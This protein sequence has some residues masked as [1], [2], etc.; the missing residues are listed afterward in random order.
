MP[1]NAME[2]PGNDTSGDGEK[3]LYRLSRGRRQSA[4]TDTAIVDAEFEFLNRQSSIDVNSIV[5]SGRGAVS[6]VSSAFGFLNSEGSDSDENEVKDTKEDKIAASDR[7]STSDKSR[8]SSVA[9]QVAKRS[10]VSIMFDF[11]YDS[12]EDTDSTSPAAEPLNTIEESDDVT[13][14][15]AKCETQNDT[16]LVVPPDNKKFNGSSPN[17]FRSKSC[18]NVPSSKQPE[19]QDISLF[20]GNTSMTS[21]PSPSAGAME[22]VATLSATTTGIIIYKLYNGSS[23]HYK[24]YM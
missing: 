7:K 12:D 2:K 17:V 23:K 21:T 4:N 18:Q 22:E 1:E 6:I 10:P 13:A 14:D 15:D 3:T 19:A 8:D 11:L 9:T 5:Q 20:S 16:T 24:V